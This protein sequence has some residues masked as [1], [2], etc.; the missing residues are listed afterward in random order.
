MEARKNVKYREDENKS[1]GDPGKAEA[2]SS[3][4]NGVDVLVGKIMGPN[5]VRLRKKF[6][7]IIVRQPDIGAALKILKE[8]LIEITEEKEK[9]ERKGLILK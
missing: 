2:T 9:T 4:L 6:V 5:I 8:N 3:V 7:P 1:H